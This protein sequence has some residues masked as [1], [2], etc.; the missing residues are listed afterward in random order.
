MIITAV[1]TSI[2]LLCIFFIF[3]FVCGKLS[4]K[5]CERML[6]H[7]QKNDTEVEQSQER[8]VEM[9]EN[10]AYGPLHLRV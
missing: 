4:P 6:N 1:T 5:F 8:D 3:G 10:V 2:I 9:M 7:E